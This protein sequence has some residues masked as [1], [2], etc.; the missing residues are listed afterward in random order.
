MILEID[1]YLKQLKSMGD[2]H[3]DILI[4]TLEDLR[5][6]YEREETTRLQTNDF[7]LVLKE[8]ILE[9]PP[10]DRKASFKKFLNKIKHCINS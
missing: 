8:V 3:T 10:M 7:V 9:K 4:N 2:C 6:K 5:D 1:A